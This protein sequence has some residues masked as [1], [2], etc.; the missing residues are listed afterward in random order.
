[1]PVRARIHSSFVSTIFWR[2]LFVTILVGTY[3][4]TA[5]IFAAIL[6]P[7]CVSNFQANIAGRHCGQ[8]YWRQNSPRLYANEDSSDKQNTMSIIR[9]ALKLARPSHIQDAELSTWTAGAAFV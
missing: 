3:P 2:S 4:A 8:S 5:V 9:D 7:I 6:R 1:M